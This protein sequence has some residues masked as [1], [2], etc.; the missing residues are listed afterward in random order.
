M[1]LEWMVS[2]SS[3]AL[4]LYD[5]ADE[6]GSQARIILLISV[7]LSLP[8]NDRNVLQ[9]NAATRATSPAGWE[10]Y[11][12]FYLPACQH[13]NLQ[14]DTGGLITSLIGAPP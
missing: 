7:A 9:L 1:P 4:R 5:S 11:N 13:G 12:D 8:S 6:S 10:T 2:T 3:T 14:T